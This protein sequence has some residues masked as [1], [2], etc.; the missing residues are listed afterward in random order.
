MINETDQPVEANQWETKE[1]EILNIR[2]MD[3]R[4]IKN[5]IAM[6]ERKF[7]GLAHK[8]PQY[9]CFIRELARRE[10]DE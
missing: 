9:R 8:S 3:T 2:E 10:F 5:C 6:P 1:G 7:R 4:H